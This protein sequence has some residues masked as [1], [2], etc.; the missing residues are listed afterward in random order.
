MERRARML[1]GQLGGSAGS[2]T[3]LERRDCRAAYGR[4]LP[5]FDVTLMETH[6]DDLRAFKK[7]VYEL[8]RQHPELLVAEEEGMTKGA[9]GGGGGGRRR[10]RG[11]GGPFPSQA[12]LAS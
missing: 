4:Q 7:E 8:F 6:L 12:L 3:P 9:E 2:P 10:R 1:A 11:R 5:R